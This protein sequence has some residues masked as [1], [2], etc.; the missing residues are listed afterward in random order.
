MHNPLVCMSF[1]ADHALGLGLDQCDTKA[2]HSKSHSKSQGVR[3]G[4]DV[5]NARS[6][7]IARKT[8]SD[9]HMIAAACKIPGVKHLMDNILTTTRELKELNLKADNIHDLSSADS[10]RY[11]NLISELRSLT[12]DAKKI[13]GVASYDNVPWPDDFKLQINLYEQ[14]RKFAGDFIMQHSMPHIWESW[15][16]NHKNP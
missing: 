3:A 5:I 10:H 9:A 15:Q 1:A 14:Q 6:R 8:D 12:R 13:Y 4:K 11:L 7:A 16:R 2:S